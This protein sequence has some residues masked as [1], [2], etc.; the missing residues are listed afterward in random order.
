MTS[1]TPPR[2]TFLRQC[3]LA[4]LLAAAP[5]PMR[6]APDASRQALVIGNDAYASAPLGNAVHDAKAMASL[7]DD[8]GFTVDLRTN[9]AREPMVDA[10]RRLAATAAGS[11]ASLIFFYY[12]GH[13]A[14]L[15]WRNF[16]LPVD[17]RVNTADDLPAQCLD[18][19][20]LMRELAK[21]KGKTF[22]VVLDACR[23]NPFGGTFR[24][25]QKGLSQF[26]A[27]AGSL[28]AF[29][30]A[31]G[32]VAADG[33]GGGGLYTRNLVRELAVKNARIEDALKRTRLAV[34][35]AS[36]GAQIPWESTSLESDV[37]LFPTHTQKLSEKALEEEFV[38]ELDTW[39]RVKG[40][41]ELDDWVAYLREYPSGKFSEI[42]QNRVAHLLRAEE[43]RLAAA[44]PP[45][46]ASAPPSPAAL[47]VPTATPPSA[48]SPPA[49]DGAAPP[50]PPVDGGQP[51]LV[52]APGL[53]VPVL[54]RPWPNPASAGTYQEFLVFSVG[55]EFVYAVSDPQYGNKVERQAERVTRVDEEADRIE[56][57]GGETV[58]DGMGNVL[59]WRRRR[60]DPRAQI[61][62][63]E[64]KVGHKWPA[65]F[66]MAFGGTTHDG[67][68][69]FRVA[70]REIVSVPAGKFDSFKLEGE[71][72]NVTTGARIVL[73]RWV[74]P[75]LVLPLR[76]QRYFQPRS[77][78]FREIELREL[79]S[80][81]QMRWSAA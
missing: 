57:N 81:R 13:G 58:L 19:G 35:I 71:G 18:F 67:Y 30:T 40:S 3:G 15:D 31:P 49:P 55:D 12:A 47:A 42:A 65:R 10:I 45:P 26:D 59:E 63:A 22:V 41:K 33:I 5:M 50:R 52:I 7:L 20:I 44:N 9:A 53:P 64:L 16:L 23:D 21:A 43:Q 1:N 4:A 25:P 37:Y 46:A 39:N 76:S 29:S 34:R 2:R 79:V 38:R 69:D 54:M 73:T 51:Q 17:A 66:R 27:P 14:Q 72:F 56:V 80:C 77:S 11:E 74:V 28:L 36:R 78:P 48:A 62:P 70:A 24:T 68:F 75:G 60:Y 8:A 61:R 32:S 6:A